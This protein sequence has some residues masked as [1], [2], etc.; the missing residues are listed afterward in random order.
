VARM[1]GLRFFRL[2]DV[3]RFNGRRSQGVHGRFK[4][5]LQRRKDPAAGGFRPG[6]SRL[7]QV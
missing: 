3:S 5:F 2:V 6:P 1:A 7:F 4:N